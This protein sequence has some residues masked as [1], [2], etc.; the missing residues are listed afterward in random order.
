MNRI[1]NVQNKA[2]T[3][4]KKPKLTHLFDN[5]FVNRKFI[6]RNHIEREKIGATEESMDKSMREHT[7]SS[8]ITQQ[9][10]NIRRTPNY[11]I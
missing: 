3:Q 5:V 9:A 10:H 4:K 2:H 1:F 7:T 8:V 11:T 6:Q